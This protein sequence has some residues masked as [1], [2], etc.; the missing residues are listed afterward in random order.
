M[1]D[2]E[3]AS[4]LSDV[5]ALVFKR[6]DRGPRDDEQIMEMGKGIDDLLGDTIAQ[7]FLVFRLAEIDKRK[8]RD[9][10]RRLIGGRVRSA[11]MLPA[12][13]RDHHQE[14]GNDGKVDFA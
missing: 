1:S 13:E 7:V 2:L 8:D 10:L 4:D 3:L 5:A 6:K 12:H 9:A 14:D 11:E